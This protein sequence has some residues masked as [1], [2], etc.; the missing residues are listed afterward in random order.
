MK[1]KNGSVRIRNAMASDA[2]AL[3][4][5]L[6]EL[7]FPS[8]SRE[9]AARL[10]AMHNSILVAVRENQVVGLLTT[11][12]M[13]VLH[14]PTAV[15]RLSA[16]VVSQKQ[17]GKGVGRA[18]VEAAEQRLKKKGCALVEVTSNLRLKDAH[19]FFRRLGYEATSVRFKKPLHRVQRRAT[20]T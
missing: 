4:E 14:R 17:R 16:L 19:S 2:P 13:K 8:T 11:N 20:D 1:P 12:V 6:K 5:L 7:G 9:V 3:S 18:L 15:G 10:K